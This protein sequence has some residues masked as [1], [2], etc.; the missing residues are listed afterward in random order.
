MCMHVAHCLPR[1]RRWAA[2]P[3]SKQGQ[4]QEQKAGKVGNKPAFQGHGVQTGKGMTF[5]LRVTS[6]FQRTRAIGERL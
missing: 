4:L 5:D 6:G 3:S 1:I 2:C